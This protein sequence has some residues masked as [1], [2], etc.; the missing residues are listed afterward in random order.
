MADSLSTLAEL[1]GAQPDDDDN[2]GNFDKLSELIKEQEATLKTL[3]REQ[4]E[5][6]ELL[7]KVTERIKTTET[8]YGRI[9]NVAGFAKRAES[10]HSD[11]ER[12]QQ[13]KVNIVK[14]VLFEI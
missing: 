4:L 5:K 11:L 8:E 9:N 2:D 3:L 7:I 14:D 6:E 12:V 10:L 1:S 13:A